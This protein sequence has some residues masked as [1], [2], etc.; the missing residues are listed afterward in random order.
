M[1][2]RTGL[3]LA[4]A[5]AIA[6]ATPA[7]AAALPNTSPI[8]EPARHAAVIGGRVVAGDHPVPGAFVR[9]FT[10]DGRPL[11]EVRS[12]RHGRFHFHPV[13]PGI[14]IVRAAKE[15]VG[16]GEVVVDASRGGNR[17]VI[18]LHD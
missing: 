8:A 6:G 16:R 1:S 5:V 14:Y 11:Q 10:E 13:R 9:L 12:H 15:G 3:V 4:S 17:V 18:E 2:L 7:F